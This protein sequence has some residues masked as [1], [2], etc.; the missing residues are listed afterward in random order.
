MWLA[1]GAG[2]LAIHLLLWQVSEPPDLFSDFYKANWQAA[3]HLWDEG[4]RATWPLTEKGGFSNLPA[5]AWLFVPLV[6]VGEELAGWAFTALGF[7]ALTVAWVLVARLASLDAPRTA[8]L[9]FFFLVNGPVVNS[10][11]EGQ[12]SHFILL[13]L[14]VAL[15][16][17]QAKREYAAGV[18]LGVCA[19]YKLPLLLLGLYFLLRRR[20]PI[21]AGGATSISIVVL[22]SLAQFGIAGLLGWYSEWIGPYLGSVVAAFNVQSINAFLVRLATEVTELRDWEPREPSTAHKI[23]RLCAYA[24]MLGGSCWLLWRG[25]RSGPARR[26]NGAPGARHLLEVVLVLDLALVISPLTWSHYYLFLLLPW[27]LYLGGKLPLPDDATTRWLMRTGF[28]LVSLPVV[29]AAPEVPSWFASVLARTTVSAWLFGGL[30][31]FAALARGAWRTD[32]N[33][34]EARL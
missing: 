28:V 17:W 10:L 29:L 8:A 27:A 19:I 31:M 6:P 16:L 11:R 20:W 34:S 26:A 33:A 25:E 5:L 7:A 2:G 9:L 22:L 14:V 21:V 13:F 1:A 3:E 23:A 32:I 15:L 24:V 18:V 12:S 30:L 4:L